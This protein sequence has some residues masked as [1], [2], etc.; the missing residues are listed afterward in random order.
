LAAF[1]LGAT[2]LVAIR[3]N[4][5]W[6]QE[7]PVSGPPDAS[8]VKAQCLNAHEEA[9]EAKIARHLGE[10]R[11]KLRACTRAECPGLV[12]ADCTN[13][14]AELAK[15][16]PSVIVDAEV[17]GQ[18]VSSTRVYVDGALLVDHL[19]GNAV[20]L[21]PG[22]HKFRFEVSGFQPQEQDVVLSEGIQGRVVVAKF[23]H[24]V[25][26][27][28]PEPRAAPARPVPSLVWIGGGVTLAAIASTA[29]FGGLAMS[30]RSSLATSCSPFCSNAQLGTV[31]GYA[32]AADISGGVAAAAA[33]L[34]GYLFFTRPEQPARGSLSFAPAPLPG[35]GGLVAARL[36]F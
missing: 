7:S 30:E 28:R 33:V 9:Q 21:D 12:R 17:D 29:V 22:P 3:S 14:L 16:F 31:R 35:N 20:E 1:V 4:A 27:P 8:E 2:G 18:Q 23:H 5:A 10:A 13:W 36:S 19:D 34:T 24:D 11:T 15:I 6:A 26:E 25:Q 32:L